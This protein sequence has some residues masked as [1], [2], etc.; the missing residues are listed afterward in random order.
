MISPK[1]MKRALAFKVVNH[2]QPGV[3]KHLAFEICLSMPCLSG[4]LVPFITVVTP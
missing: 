3:Q 1:E 4:N 2:V